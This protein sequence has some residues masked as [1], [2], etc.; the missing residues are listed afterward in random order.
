MVHH[1]RTTSVSV[2]LS[3]CLTVWL[4]VCL[5][6]AACQ[7]YCTESTDPDVTWGS[8]RGCHTVHYSPDLQ[9][10]HRLHCYG[11]TTRTRNVSEYMLVL[12]L[13]LVTIG[14]AFVNKIIMLHDKGNWLLR[15]YG[16]NHHYRYFDTYTWEAY[17]FS[18]FYYRSVDFGFYLWFHRDV[19]SACKG[20]TRSQ[21][22][23][24]RHL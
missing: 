20:S 1:S 3:V 14:E 6:T 13:C 23:Q 11:N 9:S 21:Q 5:S 7:H 24:Q 2:C 18:D 22:Q 12:A 15:S 8:D 19:N 17:T 16:H 10:V 4:C